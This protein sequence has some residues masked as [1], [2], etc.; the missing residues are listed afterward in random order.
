MGG[1]LGIQ[2]VV[3]S[4]PPP[5]PPPPPPPS[6]PPAE[7]PWAPHRL[8]LLA[9]QLALGVYMARV[10]SLSDESAG[11]LPPSVLMA[12]YSVVTVWLFLAVVAWLVSLVMKRRAS[13]WRIATAPP[14]NA[15]LIVVYLA[16]GCGA[17]ASHI[18]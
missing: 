1:A 14:L 7:S 2:R 18:T 6:A 5:P 9:G 15:T 11:R 12:V 8:A 17:Y 10:Q 16:M 3:S 4:S 13:F